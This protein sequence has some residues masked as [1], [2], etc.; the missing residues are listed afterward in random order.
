MADGD[1]RRTLTTIVAADVAGYSRLMAADEEGTLAALRSHRAD[2][3]D[4]KIDQ[5]R[6]RIANTAGDS[7]LIEFPS[8]V[9]A[10]RCVMEVQSAMVERNHDI[11][12]DRRITFRVGVH[13]GDVIAQDGDLLGDGVN[14]AARLEGLAA[15]GGICL[16]RAARDQVRDRMDV[17]L[18][19]MGEVEVKNLA[20]PVRT[21]RVLAEGS[22]DS[23]RRTGT[24]AEPTRMADTL[25]EKPSIA[26]LPFSNISGDPE[27]EFFADGLT[28]DLITALSYWNTFYVIAR[29]ST[30]Q[31]RGQSLDIRQVAH[32]LGVQY[33]LEGS[34]QKAGDRVRITAQLIDAS[35]GR[36]FW[37]ERYD[38]RLDDLFELQDEI[39]QVIAAKVEPAFAKAEQQKATRKPPTNLAAW[40][41]YQRGIASLDG[42]FKAGN[43]E[44][45]AGNIQARE[46]FQKALELDP[47]DSRALAYL[48]YAHFRFV[49]EG[50]TSDPEADLAKLMDY[51]ERA[52]AL[53]DDDPM[54]H[55]SYSIALTYSG[56]SD[57][58][59]VEARRAVDLN[60]NFS[61]AYIPLGNGLN[62]AGEPAEAVPYLEMAIKLNPTDARN[63]AYI[64]FLAE[65]HLNNRDY[66]QAIECSRKAIERNSKYPYAYFVL[67]SALGHIG[68]VS[69]AE[70][71]LNECLRLRPDCIETHPQLG[72]YKNPTD[73]EHIFVGLRQAGWDGP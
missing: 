62:L 30:F 25:P 49:F 5:Y 37:A 58:G 12:K 23:D 54:A 9:E 33:V 64:I 14:V 18:E 44:G 11:P 61:T 41:W 66:S 55:F 67:A 20:R 2:L 70:K 50:F 72:L 27:Q 10:L 26:V 35:T 29:H 7:L 1:V 13:V 57:L 4:P 56:R 15:P 65:A 32:D 3:I 6:G 46:C 51:A 59:I 52:V 48:A 21:F 60:P 39:T 22:I 42:Y 73:R 17:D 43:I 16:S 31:Y 8:V 34:V 63:H 45:K 28:E 24:L 38:R 47:S 69:D 53:D 71:A 36:H 68:Q 40:E 19:D